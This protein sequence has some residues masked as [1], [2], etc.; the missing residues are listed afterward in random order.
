MLAA[1]YKKTGDARDVVV[2]RSVRRPEVGAGQVRVK[3]AFSGINPTDVKIR[4]GPTQRQIDGFQIPH[5]DGSGTIDA[6]GPGVD[7]TRI[8]QRVWVHLA[9]HE[10][11]WGTAAE[12]TVV[13]QHRA[14]PLPDE[15]PFELAA[16][17]GVPA[18]TAANCLLGDGPIAGQDVL[19]AGGAGAV[20][21]CAVQLAHWQGARVAATVS[22]EAKA[23]MARLAGA[24]LVVNYREADAVRQVQ[25][26][27]SNV[28]RIVELDLSANLDLDLAVSMPGT[29]IVTYAVDGEDPVL[30]IRRLMTAGVSLRFMLLY[31]LPAPV[32]AAAVDVVSAA[33]LAAALQL[34]PVQLFAL[35]DTVSA[36]E[37]QEAGPL[38]RIL[39]DLS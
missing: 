9:A 36:H 39:I 17:L 21:S 19:V 22:G 29:S 24:D 12:W 13:A 2:V 4:K 18:V 3:V 34:P 37:A 10:S 15:V 6:V 27:S 35:T 28:A 16:T 31:T 1:V 23:E 38:G 11:R 8:G 32:L 5:M 20:G 30:P 14:I 33:L 26:W 25:A 7:L